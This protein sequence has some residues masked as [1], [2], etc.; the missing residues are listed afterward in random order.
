MNPIEHPGLF[1]DFLKIGKKKISSY[2]N[3]K[4]PLAIALIWLP[5]LLLATIDGM[6][7][8][9]T[10]NQS[11]LFD[12]VVHIRYLVALPLLLVVMKDTGRQLNEVLDHFIN[13]KTVNKNDQTKFEGFILSNARLQNSTLAFAVML[14][15]ACCISYYFIHYKV[16]DF[17]PSWRTLGFQG[18]QTLSLAGWWFYLVL[19]PIYAIIL[20]TVIF[21]SFLWWRILYKTSRL[22]LQLR[23]SHGDGKGGLSFLS[24]SI[25]AFYLPAFMIA[26]SLSA[27]AAD[28]ATLNEMNFTTLQITIGSVVAV[29]LILFVGP[30]FFFLPAMVKNKREAIYLYGTLGNHQLE[31]YEAKWL[32]PKNTTEKE[33]LESPD[34]S[35]II[36]STSI[37]SRVTEMKVVPF[38]HEEISGLVIAIVLPFIP[39]MAI[40]MSWKVIF[41]NLIK[42]IF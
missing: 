38:G 15:I 34:F 41:Q 8:A 11:M 6:A 33:W 26:V 29:L 20:L 32:K 7:I 31:V 27:G 42:F 10:R 5:L 4:F 23:A 14:L 19:Q 30:L 36:D 2:I 1:D 22:N 40:G 18:Q 21:R 35:S 3:K 16:V 28:L 39:I 9:P 17:A 13:S 12:F 37:S 25:K 24:E